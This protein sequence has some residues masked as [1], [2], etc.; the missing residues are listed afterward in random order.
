MSLFKGA[1]AL[2]RYRVMQKPPEDWRE[3]YDKAVRAH[4]LVPIDRAGIGV[5]SAGWCSVYDAQKLDIDAEYVEGRI[6]LS[7]RM[8][9]LKPDPAEVKKQVK[10]A[11]QRLEAERKAPLSKAALRDVKAL[12]ILDMRKTTPIKTRTVDA[13]WDLDAQ[14]LYV[15]SH[16]KKANEVFIGIFAHT[17]NIPLDLEGPG[18]WAEQYAH[19]MANELNEVA[20][21]YQCG[22]TADERA[23][24]ERIDAL[25]LK[26][27]RACRPTPELLGG[28]RGL[29]PCVMASAPEA[30]ETTDD[31]TPDAPVPVDDAGLTDRRF[32]GRE[33]LTWLVMKAEGD[34]TT[35]E[36]DEEDFKVNL[37]NRVL[38]KALGDGSAEIAARGDDPLEVRYAIAGG[39][40][41]RELDVL[42]SSG[43]RAWSLAVSAENFD[44]KRVKLPALLS[45]EDAERAHERLELI[46]QADAML[47]CAYGHF[48]SVRLSTEWP[49]TVAV[50]RVWLKDSIEA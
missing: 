35:F 46:G 2:R 29:R 44:L 5:Q 24:A 36:S 50:M 3:Q 49:A 37:G 15:L 6:L 1:L 18:F 14:R 16:S 30:P 31:T 33:F 28:F 4:A 9:V 38:C 42:F 7:L 40:T 20:E 11:A 48:L 10:L 19:G 27:L 34:G 17:F 39:L 23:G 12:V 8:D 26:M 21:K 47:E 41:V 43:D 22:S 45:E 32:L 13:V 25:R